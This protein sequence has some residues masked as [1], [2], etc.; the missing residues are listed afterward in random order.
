VGSPEG[1]CAVITG[2]TS[3]IGLA[4]A[5]LLVDGGA[6]VVVTGS[7]AGSV[8]AAREQL[9]PGA[10]VLRSDAASVADLEVLV[11]T[12]R[13]ELGRVD[14]L[15]LNAGASQTLKLGQVTEE[16]YDRVFA[17]NTRGPFFAVQHLVPLMP[18]GSSVVLTT[19]VAHGKGLAASS[20]YSAS[21]AALRSITRSLARELLRQGVRVNAVSPGPTDTAMVAKAAAT[22]EALEQMREAFRASNPMRRMAEAQE[23]ARAVLFLAFDATF[24]TGAEIPVDGG[25]SQL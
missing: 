7:S 4:T 17:L 23:V 16:D 10:V 15:F 24:T 2:G 20:V 12:V 14:L 1:K 21:K 19:S 25:A 18:A 11:E 22:P 3:G 13:T 9:G 5:K 6:R 8:D